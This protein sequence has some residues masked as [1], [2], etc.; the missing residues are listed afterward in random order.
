MMATKEHWDAI[1][2][3]RPTEDLGWFEPS[4]STLDLVRRFSVPSDPVI[5]I[6]GGDSRMVDELL[7][8]GYGD[9]TVLDLSDAAL[10]RSHT[11]LGDAAKAV[12][13][14]Q[15]DQRAGPP[16]LRRHRTARRRPGRVS[17]GRDLCARR[18]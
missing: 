3:L 5:D 9:V 8:A 17:G 6:G 16:T 1:Y 13:W 2:R 10:D 18:P 14:V 12:T 4:P 11:R 7:A 15:A